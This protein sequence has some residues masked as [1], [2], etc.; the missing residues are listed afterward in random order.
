MFPLFA[1]V[2]AISQ[3]VINAITGVSAASF[4]SKRISDRIIS[5]KIG[6]F[7]AHGRTMMQEC[8]SLFLWNLK[9]SIVLN[10]IIIT[11]GLLLWKLKPIALANDVIL[12]CISLISLF[13]MIRWAF[14]TVL[15]MKRI[16]PYHYVFLYFMNVFIKTFSFKYSVCSTIRMM[17]NKIYDENTNKVGRFTH[18]VF[19]VLRFV[20]SSDEIGNDIVEEFYLLIHDFL[21]PYIV[22]RIIAI[23]VFYSIFIFLLKPLIFNQTLQINPFE[24][25]FYPVLII[26]RLIHFLKI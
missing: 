24:I 1:I 19:S 7:V 5:G 8:Y 23:T 22:Y 11:L 14:R 4:L 2:P 13:M 18:K 6:E 17:Y 25:I 3:G 9:L 20:K 15:S 12:G 21:I 10:I 16:Y 26:Q